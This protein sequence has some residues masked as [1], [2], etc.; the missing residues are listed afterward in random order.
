MRLK[1]TVTL[2]AVFLLSACGDNAA[3]RFEEAKALL[4]PTLRRD[5]APEFR[6]LATFPGNVVCGEYN[7]RGYW[8]NRQ[9]FRQFVV[10]GKE[11]I[12]GPSESDLDI[13]CNQDPAAALQARYGI[14]PVDRKNQALLAVQDNLTRLNTAL[15]QYLED[16]AMLPTT[17]QGLEALVTASDTEPKPGTFRQGGYIDA[18]PQDPWGSPYHYLY[19]EPLRME[20]KVFE[21]YTLGKDGT[22][23]G[24]GENADISVEQLVYID[25]VSGL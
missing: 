1:L 2:G 7:A 17:E 5:S 11:A 13:Y 12:P 23:G 3:Q 19:E 21:L 25:H 8:G 10:H 24:T 20:P 18:V 16:N 9:G 15:A 4:E 14:G 22:E 6:D